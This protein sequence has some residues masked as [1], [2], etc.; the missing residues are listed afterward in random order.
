MFYKYLQ[1]EYQ[2][3]ASIMPRNVQQKHEIES[4]LTQSECI[5]MCIAYLCIH[6]DWRVS[7]R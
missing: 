7:E 1:S 2:Q 4:V 3:L 6:V 5:F